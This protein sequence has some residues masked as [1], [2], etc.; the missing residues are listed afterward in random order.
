MTM[1]ISK[2]QLKMKKSWTT[3]TI[4]KTKTQV[5]MKTHWNIFIIFSNSAIN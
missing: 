5:K 1:T 2:T 4:Q 3:V